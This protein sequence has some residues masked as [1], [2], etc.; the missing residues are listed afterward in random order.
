MRYI[1]KNLMVIFLGTV[2]LWLFRD[3]KVIKGWGNLF[4]EGY[5]SD[6]TVAIFVAML[7]FILPAENPFSYRSKEGTIPTI[8]NWQVIIGNRD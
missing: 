7:L 5:V 6:G 2:F 8:M 1:E 3:P 4:P